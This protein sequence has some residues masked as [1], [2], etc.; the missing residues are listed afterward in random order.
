MTTK[1][2]AVKFCFSAIPAFGHVFPMVP[3]AA[4]AAEAGHRVSF[5]ASSDFQKR[6]PVPVLQGVPEGLTLHVAEQEARAELGDRSDPMAWPK[7]MF[8]VV[9]PRHIVPR[10][11][12]HWEHDGPPD[13][14]IHEGS[15]FGAA[16]AAAQAGL[17]AVA[18]H[19][20]LT[21]LQSYWGALAAMTGVPMGTV[22]D[23]RPPR[24]RGDE[25]P[26]AEL[27]PQQSVPWSD[28]SAAV[29]DWLT[30]PSAGPTAYVTL[31]TVAFGAVEALR[32]SILETAEL[33]TRVLVAAG[34]EA[35][36]APLDDLPA[37]VHVER[38]VDQARALEHVDVAVHHGGTGTTLGCLASGVP[39]VITPQ[40]T[41]QFVNAARLV[42]LGLGHEVRN[43]APA[44]AVRD[45]VRSAL[46]DSDL[47]AAVRELHKEI[48]A[49]PTP[50]QVIETLADRYGG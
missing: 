47:R 48:A 16:Q 42:E 29:P 11:L 19:I 13:L 1:D 22:I 35:D 6:L 25:A 45:G 34:P 17:P 10:L 33:C 7:A 4:A 38:Y 8:G 41:D 30:E 32:R 15:N 50:A 40:G 20:G 23:P 26:G 36:L 28:P 27:I 3:L 46:N 37:H 18:F 43:D 12:D 21:P 39:Q 44:G 31:G 5:V 14:V 9:M 2:G 24:W 49:M